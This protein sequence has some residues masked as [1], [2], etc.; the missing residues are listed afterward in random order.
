MFHPVTPSLVFLCFFFHGLH[1]S[2]L[3]VGVQKESNLLT[4]TGG[5][6]R[7][8]TLYDANYPG[9]TPQFSAIEMSS[10]LRHLKRANGLK[11][12]KRFKTLMVSL[13]QP[14][15]GDSGTMLMN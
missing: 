8:K 6:S 3:S 10:I 1:E 12:W 7:T 15:Y 11:I 13:Y 4:P 2:L 9:K 5:K 14:T